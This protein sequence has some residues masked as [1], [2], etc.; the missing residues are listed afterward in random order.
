MHYID[1][2]GSISFLALLLRAWYVSVDGVAVVRGTKL[3]ASFVIYKAS[4]S[5]LFR[6]VLALSLPYLIN[7]KF[8]NSSS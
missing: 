2:A 3:E 5:I 7:T 1:Y 4:S 8:V 6:V